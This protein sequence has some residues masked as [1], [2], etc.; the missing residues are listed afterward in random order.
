MSLFGT[1][2][3]EGC[4]AVALLMVLS[5]AIHAPGLLTGKPRLAADALAIAPHPGA[6]A[7]HAGA[8]DH[9]SAV[10]RTILLPA[11]ARAGEVVRGGEMPLW[12]DR[13]RLGEPFS[14]SG[15]PVLYPPFWPLMLPDGWRFLG[16]VMLLHT[17]LA[18]MFMYRFLRAA[19]LGRYVAFLGGGMYGF[20]WFLT[21]QMDRLP[22]AAAAAL[23]PAALELTQRILVSARRTR[24][25]PL[26]G[27]AIAMMFLTG[28]TEVAGFGVAVC[29][30]LFAARLYSI[31]REE[32][33]AAFGAGALATLVAALLCAPLWLDALQHAGH[34]AERSA[35]AGAHLQPLG[36]LGFAAPLAFGNL[37]GSG[38]RLM[39]DV[40]AGADPLELVLYPGAIALFLLCLGLFRPKRTWIGV[41]W[42][43]VA[44]VGLLLTL[45]SPLRQLA[46]EWTGWR[47]NTPGASLVLLHLGVVVLACVALENFFNAPTARR[48]AVPTT[49]G[50]SLVAV[51]AWLITGVWP[52]AGETVVSW[53]TGGGA[54]EELT[55]A[56]QHLRLALAPAALGLALISVLFFVWRRLGLLN[57]KF[58]LA[59]IALGEILLVGALAPPR[60]TT[61]S[62]TAWHQQVPSSHGRLVTVG[63]VATADPTGVTPP[64]PTLNTDA[65]GILDRTA[66]LLG[67]THGDVVE[68]T[69]RARVTPLPTTAVGHPIL[70]AVG[71]D[72]AVGPA[73]PL[74][75]GFAPLAAAPADGAT[76]PDVQVAT[77]P[78][79]PRY[80]IA[81]DTVDVDTAA[82]AAT[83]MAHA[84]WPVADTVFLEGADPSFV[85]K[86]VGAEASIDVLSEKANSLELEVTM[87]VERGYLVVADAWAPG[88]FAEVDGEAAPLLPANIALRAVALDEGT[89]RVQLS[90][91]PWAMRWGMPLL[92][93]GL[94]AVIGLCL[95]FS[96]R[97]RS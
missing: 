75:G 37:D 89:H 24:L 9:E 23:L 72:V 22:T 49:A 84:H 66:R 25:G 48:F 38:L 87:G 94:V 19:S 40:N 71:L 74:E 92:G 34:L 85:C 67:V 3:R 18:C 57:F 77:R 2:R 53:V 83:R 35:P 32:L 63:G 44:G 68:V 58:L 81:Y 76:L 59:V 60:P 13:A 64:R 31:D 65:N 82:H 28:G 8:P 30:A 21:A 90:Y 4:L 27:L 78:T 17:A 93:F 96:L 52:A 6:P 69:S 20:G 39:A 80:T 15:A 73:L 10:N 70:R 5:L 62:Q 47:N 14:V 7:Q 42:I 41:F 29:V 46:T 55:A 33:R 1:G 26:L 36:L 54:A 50:L 97:P 45:D 91:R 86:A 56:A 95:A 43:V 11:M 61:P 88:W 51:L 79:A 12:N 16:L